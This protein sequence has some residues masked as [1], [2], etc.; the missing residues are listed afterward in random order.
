M[1]LSGADLLKLKIMSSG[2]VLLALLAGAATGAAL[3]IL[4]APAKGS[5]TRKELS[6]KGAE[7]KDSIKEK[8]NEFLDDISQ[9][10]DEVSQEVTDMGS[11]VK[12]EVGKKA[13]TV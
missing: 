13:K 11:S 9:K 10:Y 7:L 1:G 2:K 8:F 5:E 6:G 4:F 12:E 3:G